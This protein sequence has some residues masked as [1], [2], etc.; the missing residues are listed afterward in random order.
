MSSRRHVAWFLSL[1]LFAAGCGQK[2][3][4]PSPAPA[5]LPL[6]Y[7]DNGW[8][9][10]ER[11]EYYHLP[12]GSELMPYDLLANLK[13]IKTGKPFL[14]DMQR[15]GFLADPTGSNNPYGMPVGL[16]VARSRDASA[17]GIEMVGFNCAACHVGEITQKGK[18]LRIDGT[19]GMINLQ[20]Y[21]MEFRDS[22]NDT[23]KNPQKV[24][25]LVIAMERKEN[26]DTPSEQ[27]ANQYL[28][29]PAVKSAGDVASKPTADPTYASQSS[30]DADAAQPEANAP[31]L[32]FAQR[33]KLDIALL[34]AR[35]A[36][37]N[38]GSLILDGTEPG[39]G[40]VDAFGAAR[41]FLFS[42]YAMKMQSP[43]SFPFIWS[44]P[45]NTKEK[46]TAKSTGWIH[47]D[48]NTN[49]ILE[50]N[51]G[52]ALGMGAVFDPKTHQSS[53]RI[54]NLHRLE[55]LTKKLTPPRWPADLLGPIDT[56]KAEAGKKIFEDK[57]QSCHQNQLV[58]LVD[59]GT[60]PNR[61]NS[62][63]KPVGKEPFPT[64]IA[65]ILKGLKERAFQDEGIPPA[66]RAAMDVD[67]VIWRAPG[68]YMARALWG[69]WATAPY[70][71]NG[72]VP[73]LYH[74]LHPDQRPQKFTAGN[75]E[76]DAGKVGYQ[77]VASAPGL[78]EFDTTQPGNSNI[79]HAGERYGTTL[80]EEQKAALLEYLK[81]L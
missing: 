38:H 27:E 77:T 26:R 1:A 30:K 62:F 6:A 21:Q 13:S 69:I 81:T 2:A 9:A 41:N 34:K 65:P 49:S 47:Y 19:P 72:S 4:A 79:G 75:R 63:G 31:K 70:L 64:A 80:P 57:C 7:L 73:T 56:A 20:G 40:R 60:D 37:I 58:A 3:N 76:F 45:D 33:L 46:W 43:V 71:H 11:A 25:A 53:L 52:Q 18:R 54:A 68:K 51:I 42:Q 29:D 74:L 24:L 5:Q 59:V 15:F 23:M 48:G 78:W 28:S 14:E 16:T 66:D 22:L 36:Y 12:E 55:V 17:R 35:L 32:P 50:R 10:A 61:A 67:P 44:I 8:T 39:P